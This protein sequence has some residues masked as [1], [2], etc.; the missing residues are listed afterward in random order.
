MCLKIIHQLKGFKKWTRSRRLPIVVDPSQDG[1]PITVSPVS[2]TTSSPSQGTET[3][4]YR[5]VN[6]PTGS[7][8]SGRRPLSEPVTAEPS[9]LRSSY[10]PDVLPFYF[11]RSVSL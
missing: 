7:S 10:R 9:P 6:S 1:R 11:F 2:L 3:P 8:S 5:V 4:L